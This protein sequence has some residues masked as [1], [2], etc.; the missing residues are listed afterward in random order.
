MSYLSLFNTNLLTLEKNL[1]SGY[2]SGFSVW[3]IKNW[4]T[5]KLFNIGCVLK[6]LLN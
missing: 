2:T 4:T 3:W 5:E 1:Q 6:Q